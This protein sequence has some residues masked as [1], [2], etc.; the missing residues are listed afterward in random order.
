MEINGFTITPDSV[1]IAKTVDGACSILV[2]AK[3][4]RDVTDDAF[5]VILD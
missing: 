4:D 2:I 3:D 1:M 5:V